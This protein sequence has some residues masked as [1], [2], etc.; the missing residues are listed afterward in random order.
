[1]AC[2]ASP[3]ARR[4]IPAATATSPSRTACSSEI[5]LQHGYNTY[6]IG[7]WHLT[8][9]EAT[10]AA[11]PYDRWPLG[12]GFERYFGFLG[13]DTHQYYPELVR[14]N[15]PGRTGKDAGGGLPPHARPGREG[16]GDDRRRQAGRAQQALLHVLLHRRHA[17]AAPRAEGVG[18]QVQGQVR[19]RL[20]RLPRA[21]VR[22]AEG[23]GHH[24]REHDAVA[25]RSRR[26]GLGQAVGRRAAPL[27]ADDGGLRRLPGA[28]RPLHR[29]ADRLPQGDRANTRTP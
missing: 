10:S 27:C 5:L 1:M 14:D 6:A 25:A 15:T 18:R 11:G 2:P 23:A 28:H 8:P 22:E 29:R 13:G 17:R 4:A 26:A 12:R 16:Q 20:G 7:K 21:G 9:A 19:R 3:K 24:A